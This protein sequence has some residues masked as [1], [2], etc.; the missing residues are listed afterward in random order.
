MGYCQ[1]LQTSQLL[2]QK[3]GVVVH[4][5]F[6]NVLFFSEEVF[7]SLPCMVVVRPCFF[8]VIPLKIPFNTLALFINP[9][10]FCL[11]HALID[12]LV[13]LKIHLL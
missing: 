10:L 7:Q 9:S 13:S 3:N 1:L 11:F 5:P 2:L 12:F 4:A 6:Q 8:A